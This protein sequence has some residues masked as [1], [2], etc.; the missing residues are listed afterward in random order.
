MLL[1]VFIYLFINHLFIFLLPLIYLH[2]YNTFLN[3]K[4]H[5]ISGYYTIS[6]GYYFGLSFQKKRKRKYN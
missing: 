3:E 5:C 6:H 4:L 1:T 2:T